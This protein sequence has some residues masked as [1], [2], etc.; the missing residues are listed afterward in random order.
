M[1]SVIYKFD[2]EKRIKYFFLITD[3]LNKQQMENN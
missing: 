3:I 2:I 1:N